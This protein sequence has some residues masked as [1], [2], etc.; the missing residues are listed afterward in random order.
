MYLPLSLADSWENLNQKA[1]AQLPPV[2]EENSLRCYFGMFHGLYELVH[3]LVQFSPHKRSAAFITGT[4]PLIDPLLSYFYK[5]AYQV[6]LTSI[7]DLKDVKSW[8]SEL[9]KDTLFVVYSEDHA[10]TGE[11]Y[12]YSEIEQVCL[13][14][15]IPTIRISHNLYSHDWCAKLNLQ[16][17][18]VMGLSH[19]VAVAQ[20]GARFKASP[21]IAPYL[22]QWTELND[23]TIFKKTEERPVEIKSFENSKGAHFKPYFGNSKKRI[24]DRSVVILNEMSAELIRDRLC[25]KLGLNPQDHFIEAA[26]GCRWGGVERLVWSEPAISPNTERG[27]LIIN[28]EVVLKSNFKSIFE[29]T[30]SEVS[31]EQIL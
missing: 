31:K 13:D 7:A 3:G 8:S 5:E 23:K 4:T 17:A 19:S 18:R 12:N 26:N 21:L 16:T 27:L 10:L 24:Y 30:C 25:K 1:Q 14:L 2:S 29:E 22:P 9:A 11:I 20:I 28:A 6:Q 15:K